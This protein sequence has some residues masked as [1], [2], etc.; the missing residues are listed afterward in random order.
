VPPTLK[1]GKKGAEQPKNNKFFTTMGRPQPQTQDRLNNKHWEGTKRGQ[2]WKNAVGEKAPMATHHRLTEE[3]RIWEK[4]AVPPSPGKV[5]HH[6]Q[7]SGGQSR[8]TKNE[9]K[10]RV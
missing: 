6:S 2:G 8:S 7:N 4:K 10:T 1:Q 3:P 9:K 5:W